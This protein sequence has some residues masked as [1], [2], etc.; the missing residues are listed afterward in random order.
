MTQMTYEMVSILDEETGE[1]AARVAMDIL[2]D[3]ARQQIR[4]DVLRA[5][6]AIRTSQL[7]DSDPE[8]LE[9][10]HHL[11]AIESVA[12]TVRAAI[13]EAIPKGADRALKVDVGFM[14]ITQSR[15]ARTAAMHYNARQVLE[16][17]HERQLARRFAETLR[18]KSGDIVAALL[19]DVYET[20]APVEKISKQP[21]PTLK[22]VPEKFNLLGNG[23]W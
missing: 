2:Q 18:E 3:F 11:A 16:R 22:I 19:D 15:G 20:L 6:L 21:A 1:I 13:S 17:K 7:L 5:D 9:L 8:V 12:E 10:R 4:S 23:G 14:T